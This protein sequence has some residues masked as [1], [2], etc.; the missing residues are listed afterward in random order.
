MSRLATLALVGALAAVVLSLGA[1]APARPLTVQESRDLADCRAF[2]S[3]AGGFNLV[4]Q[5]F[6]QEIALRNCLAARGY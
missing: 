4:N 2:A 6:N 3:L 5:A 1:C